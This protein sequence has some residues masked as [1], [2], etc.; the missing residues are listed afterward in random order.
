MNYEVAW[1]F[2]GLGETTVS[3]KHMTAA[4]LIGCQVQSKR[5]PAVDSTEKCRK[6]R[7]ARKVLLQRA[8]SS[9][10][11]N[12]SDDEFVGIAPESDDED[13]GNNEKVA[14]SSD[15]EASP[16]DEDIVEWLTFGDNECGQY[17]DTSET[18]QGNNNMVVDDSQTGPLLGLH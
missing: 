5:Q 1:E 10:N 7:P 8:V 11:A 15:E 14:S 9:L 2:T 18:V 13:G 17:D 3:G 16:M 6:G 4:V 12:F